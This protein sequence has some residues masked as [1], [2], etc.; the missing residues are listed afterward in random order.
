[1]ENTQVDTK[2]PSKLYISKFYIVKFHDW[3]EVG[4]VNVTSVW[5]R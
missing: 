3:K 2:S 1:M 4:I 5:V